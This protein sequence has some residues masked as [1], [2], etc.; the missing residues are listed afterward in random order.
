[1]V[2]DEPEIPRIENSHAGTDQRRERHDGDASDLLQLA[3]DDRII[4]CVHHDLKT[5][6]D[7]SLGG[8]QRLAYIGKQR[9]R[10]AQYLELDERVSVEQLTRE[11]QR[12]HRVVGGITAC[13]V[14]QIRELGWRQRVEQR[15]RIRILADIRPTYRNSDDF[16]ARRDDRSARLVEIAVFAGAD[17]QSRAIGAAGDDQRVGE[18]SGIGRRIHGVNFTPLTRDPVVVIEASGQ[19]AR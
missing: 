3:S 19:C 17:Q 5:V 12:S 8:L 6:R 7:E 18:C 16:S 14:G 15:R 1:M 10:I 4:G 11:L 9:V 13:A 2:D